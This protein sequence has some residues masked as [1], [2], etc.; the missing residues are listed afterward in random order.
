MKFLEDVLAIEVGSRVANYLRVAADAEEQYV[1]LS[2]WS[3]SDFAAIAD[4]AIRLVTK[5]M[6]KT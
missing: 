4:K 3:T 1:A 2:N 5:E 6:Q